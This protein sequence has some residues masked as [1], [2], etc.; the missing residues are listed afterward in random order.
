MRII[1]KSED[2]NIHLCLPTNLIFSK[3]TV[4]LANHFGR[5]YAGDAMKDIPPEAMDRL[6]AE[7]RRIKRQY[8]HWDLVEVSEAD[9]TE[10]KITL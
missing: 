7:F 5:K 1:V 10:V 2:T 8:G 3:G 6:F 9:G 4:W